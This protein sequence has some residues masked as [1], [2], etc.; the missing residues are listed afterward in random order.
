MGRRAPSGHALT[1]VA[2]RLPFLGTEGVRA[3]GIRLNKPNP[4]RRCASRGNISNSPRVPA[5]DSR[6]QRGQA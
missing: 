4:I 1:A 5:R 3:V 2:Q 6:L